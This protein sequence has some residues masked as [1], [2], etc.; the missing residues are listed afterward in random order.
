MNHVV[1]LG[2]SIFD[3]G[4][5]VCPGQ[6]NV[7]T[8]VRSKLS[9]GCKV[10]L[11][12]QDEAVT[13][14][15]LLQLS[16]VPSDASHCVVSIGGNDALHAAHILLEGARTVGHAIGKLAVVREGF[17]RDYAGM[18]DAVMAKGVPTAVCTIY[19]GCAGTEDQ[20]RINVAALSIF[21]D[22]ITREA[23]ARGLP[24]IDL[25][26]ICNE[27]D[28]YANPI[29]PSV[30]GGEKIAAAIVELVSGKSRL[31]R[32]QVFT[33][34]IARQNPQF[35]GRSPMYQEPW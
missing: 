4:A 23:F 8:Q 33:A 29:E 27:P 7:A 31:P 18:L 10:A 21:N 20:Q 5:Y 26:L 24:L 15:V 6:P 32:S 3:N 17:A 35:E 34:A 28:D 14:D 30:K 1:L 16:N 19:D 9:L 25:R 2:D 13:R 22:V 12:A 11:L